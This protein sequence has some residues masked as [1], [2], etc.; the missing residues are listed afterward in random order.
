MF[1]NKT[2]GILI[3][4]FYLEGITIPYNSPD[5]ISDPDFFID[6]TATG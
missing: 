1:T 5:V 4:E 6:M 3:S 2:Y